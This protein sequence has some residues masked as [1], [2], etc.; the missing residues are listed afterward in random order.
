MILASWKADYKDNAYVLSSI[1]Q[2]W[3]LDHIQNNGYSAYT[4]LRTFNQFHV[5]RLKEHFQDFNPDPL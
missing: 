4:T 2:Q 5:Y 3:V 1:D